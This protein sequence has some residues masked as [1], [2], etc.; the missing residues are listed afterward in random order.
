MEKKN[1]RYMI[2]FMNKDGMRQIT[3]PMQGRNTLGSKEEAKKELAAFLKNNHPDTLKS[4]FES[5]CMETF[6]VSAIECYP[7]HNDPKGCW[8]NEDLNPGQEVYA[9]KMKEIMN[10]LDEISEKPG[11]IEEAL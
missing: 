1:I 10:N 3:A 11:D 2:S 5:G 9:G 4:I 7:G 8:V 6:E